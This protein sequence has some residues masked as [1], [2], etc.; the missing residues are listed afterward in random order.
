M[1]YRDLLLSEDKET[2]VD[3]ITRSEA[4]GCPCDFGYEDT[5][6]CPKESG[7]LPIQEVCKRCWDREIPE[8]KE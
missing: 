7:K 3:I 5:E 2:I 8:V 1:T 6:D 4:V